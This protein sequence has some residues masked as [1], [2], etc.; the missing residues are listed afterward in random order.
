MKT[1]RDR[2]APRMIKP[3]FASFRLHEAPEGAVIYA[4]DREGQIWEK[5]PDRPWGCLDAS[6]VVEKRV[7][8]SIAPPPPE[9]RDR[10]WTA[11]ELIEVFTPKAH[12]AESEPEPA[13]GGDFY[14]RPMDRLSRRPPVSA[15]APTKR[16]P[17]ADGRCADC[18]LLLSSDGTCIDCPGSEETRAT[19]ALS[20]RTDA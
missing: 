11:E 17:F 2:R 4:L 9:T 14:S 6:F 10:V 8:P 16:R 12:V 1:K 7:A 15:C 5:F 3:R 18:R 20:R 19:G 13:T